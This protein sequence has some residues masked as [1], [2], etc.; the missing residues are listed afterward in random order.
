MAT[1]TATS[2]TRDAAGEPEG[3]GAG[4]LQRMLRIITS[5]VGTQAATSV[6]GVVFWSLAARQFSTEALGTGQAAVSLMSV[7]ATFGT[8]GLGTLLIARVP[9]L[10]QGT[11]RVT[12][13]TAL[14]VA[15]GMSLLLAV[16]VPVVAIHGFGA[17][18]LRPLAGST[19]HLTL[20][21]VGT[22]L[23]AVALVLDQAVLVL[24]S[25]SLQL[26]RNVVASAVKVVALVAAAALGFTGGMTIFAAW[27]IGTLVS[28]PLL[29]LRTRGGWALQRD[30]A[31]VRPS[32]MR[33]LGRAAAGHHALNTVLQVPLMLLPVIVTVLLGARANGTFGPALQLTGFVFALPYAISLSL[34]AAAEGREHEV[35]E[36]MRVTLPLGLGVSALANLVLFP[37]APFVLRVLFGAGYDTAQGTTVLRLLVLAGLPFVVKDHY[38][39]LRRTQG[40]TLAATAVLAAFS[41]VE[42]VAAVVGARLDGSTGLVTGWLIVLAVEA[43]VL[44]VPLVQVRR[45]AGAAA[46]VEPPAHTVAVPP[47]TLDDVPPAAETHDQDAPP[48][49]LQ[50]LLSAI[51]VGPVVLLMA[52]GTLALAHGADLARS[53]GDS[54]TAQTWYVGGLLL[55]FVPAA[56]GILAPRTTPLNRVLLAVAMPVLL[57]LT[58]L[59][60]YPTRFMFHDEIIHGNV[61]RLI[62]ATQR[63]FVD[64]PLLPITGDYP[65]MEVAT[66][67]VAALTGLSPHT[68]A[69]VVLV[70][71]RVVMSLAVIAIV[72][73]LTG[74][75]RA[76]AVA[77]LVYVCNPQ[78]LFFNSQYSYQTLALPLAVFAVYLFQVRRV[79]ARFSLAL[80]MLAVAATSFTHHVTSALLV[81][82]WAA[83]TVLEALVRKGRENQVRS[84]AAMTA[85]SA[86][87]FVAIVLTPG[88]TLGS[89][90]GSI[91]TSSFT[92]VQALLGGKQ[93]KA[94]FQNSAGVGTAPWEQV[95][96]IASLALTVLALAPALW[97][98]RTWAQRRVTLAVLLCLVALIYPFVPAGHLTRATSEVGD[99]AAGFVFLGVAFVLGWWL[100]RSRLTWW[101]SGLIAVA[102][103]IT[104]IGSVVLGAGSISQ[105]IP[106]PYQVS[107]DARSVDPAN[108]AAAQWMAAHLPTGSH[109]YADRVGG[110]VAALDGKQFTV[111]H[112][113]SGV[114]A[115]RLLLDPEFTSAD[116]AVVR[117]AGIRYVVVDR[118]DANG[119]PNQGV[120][121]E[122]GEFGGDARTKPVP[123]AALTKLDRVLGV[124]R[125]YDNGSIAVYDVEALDAQR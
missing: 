2:Q 75:V 30:R 63:V 124:Q 116:V 10:E 86:G 28:L 32:S 107:S 27:T 66:N 106:G 93:T 68:S 60:L 53:G 89:Y 8:V 114:D 24:G 84:L 122:S 17:G 109:V 67:G 54:A 118:R 69:V 88:N 72:Q 112:I 111:R 59:V 98:A 120:Y 48:G 94:V 46:A 34:F 18:N 6:L 52:V 49:R 90:L 91:A 5:L 70:L 76:G 58:R 3:T 96:V 21:A 95:V 78:L 83:W 15:A 85:A 115:S 73:R 87:L 25:G 103:A 16:V 26:E 7:V 50:R 82:T 1:S 29:S 62:D 99:R 102:T 11:R 79:G 113:S 41:V 74:S 36:R 56:I 39:A 37:L 71:T 97:R 12:V 31:L 123:L 23:M 105:Q 42:I 92:D 77:G 64:N 55:V 38:V 125:L 13:R 45:T 40:R 104:F 14:A 4:G 80:P 110:L 101:R 19:Q 108:I 9:H 33:G 44:A 117:A 61:L 57:Q 65:G 121:V 22:S 51:G 20:F 43:V 100:T 47:T 119:L 81:A 35:V